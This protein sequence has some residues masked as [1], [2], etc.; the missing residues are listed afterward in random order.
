MSEHRTCP[1]CGLNL[2]PED[3]ACPSCG[4]GLVHGSQSPNDVVSAR[5]TGFNV[6][7][8][9]IGCLVLVVLILVLALIF[10]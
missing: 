8:A 6:A 4:S 10:S 1:D 9:G 3:P 2:G 5:A 7:K